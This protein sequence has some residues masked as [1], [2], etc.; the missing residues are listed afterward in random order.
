MLFNGSHFMDSVIRLRWAASRTHCYNT[1][2]NVGMSDQ[3]TQSQRSGGL[4]NYPSRR[5]TR[6]GKLSNQNGSSPKIEPP[7]SNAMASA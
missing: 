6:T 3:V 2:I 7:R 5:A 4:S 1:E